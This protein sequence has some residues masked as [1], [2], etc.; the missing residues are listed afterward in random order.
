MKKTSYSIWAIAIASLLFA[1]CAKEQELIIDTP[2]ETPV[3]MVTLTFNAEKAGADTKTQADIDEVAGKVS[4]QWVDDDEDY[5]TVYL[6]DG[7]KVTKVASTATKVSATQMKI[8]ATVPKADTYT[9]RAVLAREFYSAGKP[10]VSK[11]Q[12]P[13]TDNFDPKGD[14]LFSD[15]KV[16][17][18]GGTSTGDML[19]TFNRK[20]AINR[21]T[22]KNLTAG[23]KIS[24]IEISSD[25]DLVGYYDGADLVAVSDSKQLVLSYNNEVILASGEFPVYFSCMEESGHT[26]TVTVTTDAKIYTKTFGAGGIN[27]ALGHFL[28]FR[29]TMPA[30]DAPSDSWDLVTSSSTALAAGDIIVLANNTPDYA[31]STT[32]NSNNRAATSATSAAGGSQI[33]H[34]AAIQQIT[35][36]DATSGNFYFKVGSD[37]YLYAAS[38]S[39][40]YLRSDTKTNVGDNGKWSVSID[41]GT[42]IATIVAQGTNTRNTVAYNYNSGT[43]IFSCYSSS[44]NNVKIYRKTA[45]DDTVWN[46][47]SLA[48]DDDPDKTDYTEGDPFD[49]TGMVVKATFE[50]N[51]GVKPN[52]EVILGPS[53]FTVSPTLLSAGETKVTLSYLNKT[54]DVTGLTVSVFDYATSYTS[55]LSITNGTKCSDATIVISG[56]NFSGKKLGTSGNGGDF[57]VTVPAGSSKLHVHAAGWTGKS[58]TLKVTPVENVNSTNPVDITADTG[59]SG[60]GSTFTLAAPAMASTGYYITFDLKDITTSTTLTV[61]STSERAVIWGVHVE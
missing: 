47:V 53:D 45:V 23:E 29:V 24:K 40:N 27:F 11:Y 50:D 2:E 28:Q 12:S 22:L 38:S 3:E 60:S 42:S 61:A 10:M 20:V 26:L 34:A 39:K 59:V 43:P 30:G 25:K 16:V 21:M 56:S 31:L 46:L 58:P 6:V 41:S 1:S 54:V 52:K 32:Q 55:S 5:I 8:T 44:S 57:T 35:L 15:D 33:E 18:T 13:L 7:A 36:E 14:I 4:Y 51:A 17:T 9:I 49:P 48:V 37:S 19:L